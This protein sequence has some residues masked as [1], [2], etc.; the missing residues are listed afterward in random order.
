MLR[1][2]LIYAHNKVNII[3]IGVKQG[4]RLFIGKDEVKL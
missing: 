3:A 2:E 1:F 4:N